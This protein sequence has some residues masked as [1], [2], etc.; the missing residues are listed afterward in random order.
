MN[1]GPW[2]L[3]SLDSSPPISSISADA[4]LAVSPA[5]DSPPLWLE[6][7][8]SE[9][10]PSE[11]AFGRSSVVAPGGPAAPGEPAA[12]LGPPALALGLFWLVICFNNASRTFMV[13]LSSNSRRRVLSSTSAREHRKFSRAAA[14]RSANDSLGR[15]DGRGSPSVLSALT[16]GSPV[17]LSVFSSG[18]PLLSGADGGSGAG[19]GSGAAVGSGSQVAAGAGLAAG[20]V[21]E[22]FVGSAVWC[23]AR[24]AR[25]PGGAQRSR[26][27]ILAS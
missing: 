20:G 1:T 4:S 23:A 18:F 14:R 11:A 2:S 13:S 19:A 6:S 21:G 27:A 22:V 5:P 26:L 12:P 25:R 10:R 17:V 16:R 8:T 7:S 24:R 9:S 15:F 3:S